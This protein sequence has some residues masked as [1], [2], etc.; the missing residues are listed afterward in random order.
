MIKRAWFVCPFTVRRPP[1]LQ[2]VSALS[3]AVMR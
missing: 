3:F 1:W 2:N